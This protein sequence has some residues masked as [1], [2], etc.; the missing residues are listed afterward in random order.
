MFIFFRN[1]NVLKQSLLFDEAL[2]DSP[3]FKAYLKGY[4]ERISA[5]GK[6]VN[7]VTDLEVGV[8]KKFHLL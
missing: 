3:L 6:S 4:E 5:F 2:R 1:M 7:K 8:S